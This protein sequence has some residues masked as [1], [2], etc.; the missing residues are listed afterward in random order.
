MKNAIIA[1]LLV[2]T[3]GIGALWLYQR[4]QMSS[5]LTQTQ[6]R[7]AAAEQQL[8]EKTKAVEKAAQSEQR[9]RNLQ[10]TL[11][12]TSAAAG[13]QSKQVTQLQQSLAAARTNKAANPLSGLFQD[14]NMREMIKSQQKAF[15]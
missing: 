2:A 1:L 12:A 9:T 14:A 4:S 15:L 8:E 5:Q 7:L 11:A 13:E 6:A 3:I 10:R